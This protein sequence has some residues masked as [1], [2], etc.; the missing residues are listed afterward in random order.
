MVLKL[1]NPSTAGHKWEQPLEERR[2]SLTSGAAQALQ[3][4]SGEC[5]LRKSSEVL[6]LTVFTAGL[7]ISGRSE[8]SSMANTGGCISTFRYINSIGD[9][10]VIK[11][12]I[13]KTMQK[14]REKWVLAIMLSGKSKEQCGMLPVTMMRK[15]NV[16]T[17]TRPQGDY[18]KI[19][20]VALLGDGIRMIFVSK[21]LLILL[22]SF[23][24]QQ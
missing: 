6:R 11:K 15:M 1:V 8:T 21:F 16:C 4:C 5:L 12:I 17:W 18:G 13:T 23:Y 19:K 7:W 2:D 3:S 9:Y 10:A 20:T 24:S 14:N 22:S